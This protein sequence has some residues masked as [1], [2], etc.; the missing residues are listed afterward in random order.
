MA[1]ELL[2]TAGSAALEALLDKFQTRLNARLDAL[3][4]HVHDMRRESLDLRKQINEQFERTQ[5][6]INELGIRINTVD[7]R[8]DTFLN[9][10]RRDSSKMDAWLERLVRVEE[11]FKPSTVRTTRKKAG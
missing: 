6:L 10:A 2:K 5:N 11:S 9:F 1:K 8:L 7:T 4:S 3:E